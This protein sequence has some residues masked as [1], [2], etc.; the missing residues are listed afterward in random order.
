MRNTASKYVMEYCKKQKNGFLIAGD[1][2]FG[3]WDS[4]Q[5]ELPDQYLNPG[6]N[7]A[8]TIGL[9]AG[10]ALSGKRV[11]IYNIIPF[12]I[13]R[14]Y[15]QVRLD[16]CYQNLPV[17]FLGIGSGITYAPAGMTHY[18]IEDITLAKTMPN[19]TI[20]SPSDPTGVTKALDYA[21]KSANPTYIRIAKS[22]EPIIFD[23]SLDI[24]QPTLIKDGKDSAIIFHGS[25]I[26]EVL[27][28][29]AQLNDVAVIAMPMINPIDFNVIADIMKRYKKIFVA[30]EHYEF[31]GLGMILADFANTNRID[32]TVEKIAIKNEYI[33]DIGNCKYLRSKYAID[34]LSI[35]DKVK[36]G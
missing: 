7:E 14:C 18:S 2:G 21:A 1:A 6:I 4:F 33:H 23:T 12:L 5:Q 34:A 13:M 31:G 25:I 36:R 28:A 29:S 16:I 11:F 19:L 26:D 8:A 22:G 9:A 32:C 17:T 27:E 20:I 3:V 30:E 24:T 35:I 15:E 10:M